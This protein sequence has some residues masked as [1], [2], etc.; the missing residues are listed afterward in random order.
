MMWRAT[1]HLI[2]WRDLIYFLVNFFFELRQL[3]SEES[4]HLFFNTAN[5]NFF[6]FDDKKT[7][8][9]SSNLLSIIALLSSFLIILTNEDA[10]NIINIVKKRTSR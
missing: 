10:G 7:F 5:K 4:F 9:S 6:C 2:C 8:L 1:Q 3:F